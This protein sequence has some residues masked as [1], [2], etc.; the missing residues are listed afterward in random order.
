MDYSL[1][2][3]VKGSKMKL[4]DRETVV[5]YTCIITYATLTFTTKV[6]HHVTKVQLFY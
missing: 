2:K 3:E 4:G 1:N 5:I 6:F